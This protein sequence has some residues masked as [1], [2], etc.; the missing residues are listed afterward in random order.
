MEAE[1][2]RLQKALAESSREL[3]QVQA[4]L[5][6]SKDAADN[7]NRGRSEFL[8]N[9]AHEFRMHLN[10][11]LGYT[12]IFH[13]ES[14]LNKSYRKT[15]DV[16][17]RHSEDLLLFLADIL[18]LS[19]IEARHLKLAQ[20]HFNLRR[21]L[22]QIVE[23]ARMHAEKQG[24][25]FETEFAA[26]LPKRVRGD[27]RRLRQIALNL[28]NNA[29]KFT[30]KG[31]VV[32]R[33]LPCL[34]QPDNG[35]RFQ[36][37]D[38]GIGIPAKYSKDIF[39][40]FH[41]GHQAGSYIEGTRLGLAISQNLLRLMG[42]ELHV[43]SAVGRGSTFWFEIKFPE[44]PESDEPEER[45]THPIVVGFKGALRKVLIGDAKYENRA[46]LKEMLLPIGFGI[47]EAVDG[48]D[49]LTKAAQHRP[50]LIL[51]DLTLP[52]L[53]GFEA[54]RH[55]RQMPALS[56]VIVVSMSASVFKQ[57]REERARAGSDDFLVKPIH[58]DR[59]L[60]CLQRHLKLVWVY[61]EEN[62]A[63]EEISEKIT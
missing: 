19:Q 18:D 15:I 55:I 25:T 29:V 52:V 27:E 22:W 45:E 43:K 60:E 38:T 12:Q 44:V 39:Q 49:V 8:A 50:D 62:G 59:L 31:G 42:S 7:A 33:V 56:N 3:Q 48:F 26:D 1:K 9:M 30:K 63:A 24:L 16:V 46:V 20:T 28:L 36:V 34:P 6:A 54:I 41:S 21:F 32:F 5:N 40:P 2:C 47:V 51:L 35:I 13:R 4:E 14:R 37:E 10:V 58:L 61:Q 53:S 23:I 11:I 57:I 17:H